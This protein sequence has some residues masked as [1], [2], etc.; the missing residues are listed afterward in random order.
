VSRRYVYPAPD[1]TDHEIRA[2]VGG[3]WLHGSAPVRVYR[4]PAPVRFLEPDCHA[5]ALLR[6]RFGCDVTLAT[7]D[8]YAVPG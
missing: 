8:N 2:T 5:A 3:A 4:A 1:G 7:I 6:R